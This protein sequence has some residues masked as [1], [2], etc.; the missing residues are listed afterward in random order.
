MLRR[1][2]MSLLRRAATIAIRSVKNDFLAVFNF[3]QVSPAF[4]PKYHLPITWTPLAHFEAQMKK[5][6][7]HF[8]IVRLPDALREIKEGSLRG[9]CAAITLDDGD[10]SLKRY[11][12]PLLQRY[13]IPATYF[14][15]T[16]YW[17]ARRTYWVYLFRYL[18]HNEMKSKQAVLDVDLNEE[19]EILRNTRDP[20]VYR[21]LR[22]R[23]EAY[24]TLVDPHERFFVS[25]EFLQKLDPKLFS[26][27]LHGHEHQ[28]FSMMPQGWQRECI[29]K[30][31]ESLSD[32][33]CYCPIF[34]VPFGRPHDLDETVVRLRAEMALEIAFANGGINFLGDEHCQRMPADGA[35]VMAVFRRNMVGW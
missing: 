21:E 29:T 22:D 23:V 14:I 24:A 12:T 27:G 5:I 1:V 19:F 33:P 15:N 25:K 3:H 11:V 2:T 18:I 32:L 16:G 35:K 9:R 20:K 28:R 31:I 10:I 6:R 7:S 13:R 34:A 4:D 26:V 17:G 8:R 30:N